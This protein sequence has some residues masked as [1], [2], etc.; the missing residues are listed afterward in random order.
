MVG[1]ILTSDWYLTPHVEELFF[2]FYSQLK[3][4]FRQPPP[5][6]AS[7]FFTFLLEQHTFT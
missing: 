6:A 2:P 3:P 4:V 5:A 7:T 1:A